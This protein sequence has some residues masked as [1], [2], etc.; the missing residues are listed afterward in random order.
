MSGEFFIMFS[1]G[2]VTSEL[3]LHFL[4]YV[5]D[6]IRKDNGC[7]TFILDNARVH[8][9]DP[10]KNFSIQTKTEFRFLPPRSPFLNLSE[11]VFR[12]IKTGLRKHLTLT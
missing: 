3:I 10:I 4:R 12:Y 11:L 8:L 7:L 2:N 6:D 9:T 1:K 5:E